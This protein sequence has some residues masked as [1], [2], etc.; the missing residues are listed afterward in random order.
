MS[1]VAVIAK[2]TAKPG[3]HDRVH[4]ALTDLLAVARDEPGTELYVLNHDS[5]DPN[6]IWVYEL[7]TDGDALAAHSNSDGM[8]AAFGALGD[9]LAS[10]P[11]LIMV[12]PTAAKG[13]EV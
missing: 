5:N 9:A 3:Q 2:L 10:A 6:T 1:K 13:V 4:A 8:K 12:E 7:Y 11:E